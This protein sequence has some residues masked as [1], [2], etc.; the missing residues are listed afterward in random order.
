LSEALQIKNKVLA[1]FDE[2]Y[3]N[4][5]RGSKVKRDAL[6]SVR[7]YSEILKER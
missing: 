6:A 3:P 7:C 2:E 4:T 5:E 1:I